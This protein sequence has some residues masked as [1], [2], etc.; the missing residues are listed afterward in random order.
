[1][2][3]FD[4]SNVLPDPASVDSKISFICC[5]VISSEY[6]MVI[7]LQVGWSVYLKKLD[8]PKSTFAR[9]QNPDT[10]FG[11][12]GKLSDKMV[13][14]HKNRIFVVDPAKPEK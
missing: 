13:F 6:L 4:D 11:Y 7:P 1:M 10:E 5:K 2:I 12:A 8:D 9:I 14:G 3:F